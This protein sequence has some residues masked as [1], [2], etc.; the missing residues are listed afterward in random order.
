MG[1]V[2]YSTVPLARERITNPFPE[3]GIRGIKIRSRLTD[4]KAFAGLERRVGPSS[5]RL[6]DMHR[7]IARYANVYI[8]SVCSVLEPTQ[9]EFFS[10]SEMCTI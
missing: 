6:M 2:D 7:D 4:V 3:A 8:G 10:L 1:L 5:Q 9:D